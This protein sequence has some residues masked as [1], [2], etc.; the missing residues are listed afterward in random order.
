MTGGADE[1]GG[2]D[3]S[4]SPGEASSS[5]E[6]DSSGEHGD[7]DES[8]DPDESGSSGQRAARA[9]AG[10]R[11][12][13][14]ALVAVVVA[15]VVAE[16]VS[17]PRS[18]RPG[19]TGV[20]SAAGFVAAERRRLDEESERV[21]A[22]REALESAPGSP[23]S[24][25]SEPA[26]TRSPA[27]VGGQPEPSV[28]VTVPAPVPG[29][30]PAAPVDPLLRRADLAAQVGLTAVRGPAVTV[31][32]DDAPRESRGGPLPAGVPSPGPND[33]VVH[34]QDVQAVVNALWSGGAEAMAIMGQRVTPRTAVR[35]VGNT[36]LL[37]DQVY[38]PPFRISA[39][40]DPGALRN[41][42]DTD[43][44]VALYRDYVAAYGLGYRVTSEADLVLPAYTGGSLTGP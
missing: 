44:G 1:S 10:W 3:E 30:A 28:T 23:A 36:L 40:G 15:V 39:I 22:N 18:G 24:A 19:G 11:V 35:C 27:T 26:P 31:E 21:R 13:A 14:A 7:P 8:R 16:A 12:L 34:Q 33:L 37:E 17:A 25:P 41:V 32:L 29:T 20:L 43:P 4:S 6:S 5:G 9:V 2:V 42:L 38:S